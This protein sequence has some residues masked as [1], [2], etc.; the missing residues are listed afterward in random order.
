VSKLLRRG[1]E[2][3]QD[4]KSRRWMEKKQPNCRGLHWHSQ[5]HTQNAHSCCSEYEIKL[6]DSKEKERERPEK[7]REKERE[8]QNVNV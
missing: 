5:P 4:M 2:K 3:S 8:K 7:K 1:P 6:G